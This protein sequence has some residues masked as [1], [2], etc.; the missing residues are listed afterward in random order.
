MSHFS[1]ASL[2]F[3]D[4]LEHDNSREFWNEHREDYE[5]LVRDPLTALADGFV[6][7]YGRYKMFR[8]NRDVRFSADK[9][10][11]KTQ[12]GVAF[13]SGGYIQLSA[14]GLACGAGYYAMDR[15]QLSRYRDAIMHERIG[16]SLVTLLDSLPKDVEVRPVDPLKT[17]PR[18]Y[19]VD[20]PRIELLRGK[21]LVLW[22][23]WPVEP[24][25]FESAVRKPV[26][27]FLEQAQ[28]LCAWLHKYVGPAARQ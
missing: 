26:G 27:V 23:E 13:E 2:D 1:Q 11:Y 28:P 9:S 19:P 12:A 15:D 25:L 16:A 6:G 14:R 8:P 20:H 22:Q 24:W 18:G 3:Y 10:P 4:A 17:A 5:R 7:D 21:G